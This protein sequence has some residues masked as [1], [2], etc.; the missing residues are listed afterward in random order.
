MT[1][2][3]VTQFPHDD[4]SSIFDSS[5]AVLG[6]SGN[7]GGDEELIR[8]RQEVS[9]LR[10]KLTAQMKANTRLKAA[11]NALAQSTG[12]VPASASQ[13]VNAS[14]MGELVLQYSHG[15]IIY[16]YILIFCV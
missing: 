11:Y 15:V 1:L 10:S 12:K 6:G 4:S 14:M 16:L 2:E 9:A 5:G 13:P 3:E 8:T 7:E